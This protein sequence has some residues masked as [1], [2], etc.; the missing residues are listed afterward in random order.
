M[1]EQTAILVFWC[2]CACVAYTYGV[3]PL[4]VA[5][6]ASL[7]RS[8]ARG[9][10]G[11]SVS[12]VVAAYN[13]EASIARRLEELLGLLLRSKR[14]GELILVSDGSTDATVHAAGRIESDLLRIIELRENQ[15]K[16]AAISAACAAAQGDVIVLADARQHWAPDALERLL[17]NFA[18][19]AIGGVS[20]ELVLESSPGLLAGVGAY[21]RFE[22]WLRRCEG[23]LHST[24][25]AT[26]AICAVRRKLFLPI[27][28]GTILDDVYWP[29]RVVMQGYRVVHDERARAYDRL[30]EKTRDEFRRKVR[31]LSGNLQLLQRL[32]GSILPWKN[33]IWVQF[34]SHK[35]LRLAV[36]WALLLILALSLLLDG[37]VYQATGCA[38]A[39]AGLAGL[40]GM[41]LPLAGRLPG[42]AA[43][44]SFLILN[45]AAWFAFWIW[46][47]GMSAGS[48]TKVSYAAE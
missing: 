18:D 30:P 38:L 27:P 28:K 2:A 7:R 42:A 44:S 47:F 16:A 41:A 23:R 15:G 32:P 12:I 37:F 1:F 17:E 39:A 40:A 34:V 35:L 19:P 48:W 25:G 3:Y 26:G 11:A 22:K 36:P 43:L 6:L 33:P 9:P 24:V 45:A 14:R 8:I 31:T 4:L 29:L 5:I 10:H 13:E 20:G 46:L 21:W